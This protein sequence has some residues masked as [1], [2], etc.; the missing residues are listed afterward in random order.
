[1]QDPVHQ[2]DTPLGLFSLRAR[3]DAIVEAGWR[4]IDGASPTPVLIEA[5]RQLRAYWS[6]ELQVFD[7]PVRVEGGA[8]VRAV[9][10][11][12]CAIPFGETRTYGDLAK[13]LGRPAQAI[14][15][16]CGQNPI[17]LIIPCH[18]VL[19][20]SGLG[21]FSAPGGVETK[22]ALLRHEGAAGL[23]I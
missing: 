8:L 14:G 16:A 20:A 9:C 13:D 5:E 12:L 11:L 6:G 23:L 15:Q 21:G 1:M 18:R 19:S 2:F 3:D 7:L 17:P 10:D 22:V 4:R